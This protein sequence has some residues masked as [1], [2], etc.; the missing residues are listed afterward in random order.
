MA[1]KGNAKALFFF[2]AGFLTSVTACSSAVAF[3]LASL[4][5][6]ALAEVVFFAALAVWVI[7]DWLVSTRPGLRRSWFSRQGLAWLRRKTKIK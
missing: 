4:V 3:A 7:V 2:A 6:D 5:A 1:V